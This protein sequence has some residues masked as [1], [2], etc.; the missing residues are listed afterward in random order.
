[1]VKNMKLR[2]NGNE[3]V[4][5]TSAGYSLINKGVICASCGSNDNNK[6][7]AVKNKLGHFIAC[8]VCDKCL[9]ILC[10]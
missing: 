3:L 2:K 10:F 1:M 5:D 7:F 6:F 9:E 8:Y 4:L